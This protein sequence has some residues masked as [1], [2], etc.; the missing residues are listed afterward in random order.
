MFDGSK[1][2]GDIS[3]WDVGNVEDMKYMFSNCISF[4]KP[5]NDWNVSDTKMYKTEDANILRIDLQLAKGTTKFKVTPA[6][7]WNT[8]Y[9]NNGIIKATT[10]A[11]SKT[12]WVMS[13]SQN[14]CQL[15]INVAGVYTFEFNIKTKA[16]Y[17]SGGVSVI[18]DING[19]NWN[20]DHFMTYQGN[21][22]FTVDI[23]MKKGNYLYKVRTNAA[24]DASWGANFGG[25]NAT[26][27]VTEAGV[28]RFTI[29]FVNRKLTAVL[30][31]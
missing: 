28:Y 29:D 31:G 7:N 8:S 19:E 10:W 23:E 6:R 11:T 1:F 14:D 5:L 22:V 3:G 27:N 24:W 13:T 21:G 25:S 20:I 26:L 12:G 9:G 4:N 17:V 2:N 30:V 16:V 15:S 18:G